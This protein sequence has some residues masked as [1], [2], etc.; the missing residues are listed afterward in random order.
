MEKW[1]MIIAITNVLSLIYLVVDMFIKIHF[2]K[3]SNKRQDMLSKQNE[4]INGFIKNW[5]P[6]LQAINWGYNDCNERLK[7]VEERLEL[8]EVSAKD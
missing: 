1:L 3:E 5:Q 7:K 4:E 8:P 6:V 2:T